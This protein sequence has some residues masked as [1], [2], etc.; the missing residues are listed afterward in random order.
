MCNEGTGGEDWKTASNN[1]S[2]FCCKGEQT[3]RTIGKR[4]GEEG[5]FVREKKLQQRNPVE[6]EMM[7][8][9]REERL[10]GVDQSR[11][12]LVQEK[13]GHLYRGV[14]LVQLW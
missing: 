10:A 1:N 2:E 14:W 6:G 11:W 8:E 3:N 9:E 12:D 5:A 4:G 13:N 7:L